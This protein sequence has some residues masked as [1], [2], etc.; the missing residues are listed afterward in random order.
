MAPAALAI[1]VAAAIVK[2]RTMF[3][4]APVAGIAALVIARRAW[5]PYL[6][7]LATVGTFAEPYAY[8]QFALAGF[9]PFLSELV[10][11]IALGAAILAS[12]SVRLAASGPPYAVKVA[13]GLLLVAV[14]AGVIVGMDDGATFKA[15][16]LDMRPVLFLAAFWLALPALA[17]PE[18]RA[19]V[20]WLAGILAAGVVI[21]QFAQ[22]AVGTSTILFYTKD[23]FANLVTCPTGP[24]LDPAASGFLRVRPPG[25]NLAYIATAFSLAY[26]LWGPPRR[27]L[28]VGGLFTLCLAGVLAS[29][30]RNM[31][32]GLLLGLTLSTLIV[33][34]G[35]RVVVGIA[36]AGAA[37]VAL[38]LL[39]SAGALGPFDP[40]FSRAGTLIHPHSVAAS[41][42]ATDRSRENHLAFAALRRTP[43]TGIG[44]G[45]SYGKTLATQQ[46]DGTL[47]VT[48]QP[49]IHNLYLGL[50]LRTGLLGLIAYVA[51]V[52]AAIGYGVRWCRRRRWDGQSWL[53]AAVVLALIANSVSVA[54]DVGTDPEKLVP[55]V[56]VLALAVTLAQS[57]RREH[58]RGES[59]P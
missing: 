59:G 25:I 16:I 13:L 41:A 8:H 23:P 27:R 30:N 15:A 49:F 26:L 3:A 51:A 24:C 38:I 12:D 33:A 57:L 40:A 6:L 52:L 22:I 19:R 4:L 11:L 56:G 28:L 46:P 55:F 43:L 29:L 39:N 58:E 50:W 36:A 10:L 1:F 31:V 47:K 54:L 7:V 37:A 2:G 17:T 44:W 34:R 14:A 35:G 32:L 42:S 48:D 45:T 18:S 9:N 53:G 20:F 5:L 21:L